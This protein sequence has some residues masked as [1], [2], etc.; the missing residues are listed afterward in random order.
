MR[1]EFHFCSLRK[2]RVWLGNGLCNI[3]VRKNASFFLFLFWFL[4]FG[5]DL[6]FNSETQN[7]HAGIR[8]EMPFDVVSLPPAFFCTSSFSSDCV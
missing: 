1:V 7:T 2:M 4:L 8:L 5:V 6:R 3:L